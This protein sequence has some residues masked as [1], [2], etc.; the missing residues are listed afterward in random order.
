MR[1]K[2][3]I[4]GAGPA[5]LL[6]GQL[7]HRQGIETIIVERRSREY[8]LGRIRAGVLEQGSVEL[9][10]KAGVGEHVHAKGLVHDGVEFCFDGDKNRFNFRELIGRTVTVYGQTEVTRDLMQARD[11]CGAVSIYEA[12]KVSVHDFDTDK[13]K[14]RFVKDGVPQEIACDFIAGCDGYHGVCRAS[15]PEGALTTFERV[16]PF[17]WLGLLVDRPPV[18]DEL[19]Y[20][21]HERGF[22]LCSMRSPTRSR[23]YVQ[24]PSGEK[25]EDWSDERFWDELRRRVDR[26][27]AERLVTGPSIEKSIAPLRSFVAEPLRFGRL[28]LAGDAAHIV[29]PTGAKGLNLAASDVGVLA[30]A[31]TEYYQERSPAGIDGYSAR[32]LARVWKAERF[33]WWMT[34]ILH[35]FPETDAFGRRMQRT[36]FDYLVSSEAAAKAM[37]ENY[38]GLPL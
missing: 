24:V 14:V 18:A 36:E 16:Y 19:I 8:V 34:S 5:G 4:I 26:E 13:P 32:V 31:L 38:T 27:T 20:A 15:V 12:D 1:T 7:L 17:G 25:V 37:A 3:A 29:P 30:E 33:S 28:F 35:T 6:L 2:V 22:A 11:D 21:H 23:Y 9:L 10:E